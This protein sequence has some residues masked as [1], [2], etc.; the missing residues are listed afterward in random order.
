MTVGTSSL[1]LVY[2]ATPEWKD[3]IA[4]YTSGAAASIIAAKGCTNYG[5]GNIAASICKYILNDQKTV[6]PV[7]FYQED[8]G[9]SLSMPAVLG[10]KGIVREIKVKLDDEEQ[11]ALKRSADALKEVVAKAEKEL[12]K[13]QE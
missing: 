9:V 6:R 11:K 1:D 8:L 4:K 10:R 3:K 2:D 12:E 13:I 7:S 5:I